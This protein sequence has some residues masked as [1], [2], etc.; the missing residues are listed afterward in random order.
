M[1]R[2][3]PSHFTPT[4]ITVDG[5]K[6]DVY[7]S[8]CFVGVNSGSI[9]HERV[10]ATMGTVW[11]NPASVGKCNWRISTQTSDSISVPQP[12]DETDRHFMQVIDNLWSTYFQTCN[13]ILGD[14]NA[15]VV[16]AGMGLDLAWIYKYLNP[17]QIT[18][19][20][21]TLEA[22]GRFIQAF[23]ELGSK[24]H[25][26]VGGPF[27]IGNFANKAPF[28]VIACHRS[29]SSL[30]TSDGAT[31]GD[32]LRLASTLQQKGGVF[33]GEFFAHPMEGVLRTV[34]NEPTQPLHREFFTYLDLERRFRKV[35]YRIIDTAMY[36]HGKQISG[37]FGKENG[38]EDPPTH[39]TLLAEKR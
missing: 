38:Q 31:I 18:A 30:D 11:W 17:R 2:E 22:W 25:K 8:D 6:Y 29:I 28:N 33:A 24:I 4:A 37:Y 7:V 14:V 27:S 36:H 3:F 34:W 15:L 35:G 19:T 32:F 9:E 10:N 23:P 26:C 39:Y 16:G 5:H 12:T 20:N 13:P 1:T 21:L